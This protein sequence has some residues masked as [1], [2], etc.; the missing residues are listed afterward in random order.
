MSLYF[1]YFFFLIISF[2]LFV[3]V[4]SL[5]FIRDDDNNLFSINK[6]IFQVNA[7]IKYVIDSHMTYCQLK[8]I[9]LYIMR[10]YY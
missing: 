3:I 9:I 6:H 8:Q 2:T 7:I 10:Q 4:P 5:K 1:L